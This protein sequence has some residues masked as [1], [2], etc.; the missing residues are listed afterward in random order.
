MSR[1]APRLFSSSSRYS[2]RVS[3]NTVTR[4]PRAALTR[5]MMSSESHAGHGS[6]SSDKPWIIGSALVFGPLFLYFVS[7]SA[8]KGSHGHDIH[9]HNHHEDKQ[10][11]QIESHREE[12]VKP[13]VDDEGTEISGQ[14]VKESMEK[15]F[16]ADSP[17][18]A[19]EREEVVAKAEMT[20]VEKSTAE[21]EDQA[22]SST[23]ATP[24]SESRPT[25]VAPVGVDE[26]TNA[27]SDE[28]VQNAAS[29]TGTAGVDSKA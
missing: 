3:L 7:P 11:Q 28:K 24:E 20:T 29:D 6:T 9:S 16:E 17:K 19:Q 4:A 10:A 18:G 25:P 15:A 12:D 13:M 2:A 5:R 22:D 14:E 27:T 8:R 23:D 1:N 21:A 26:A